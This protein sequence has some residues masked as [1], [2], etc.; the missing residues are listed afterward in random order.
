MRKNSLI[1]LITLKE[2]HFQR[3]KDDGL[4]W[5]EF[6]SDS[7]LGTIENRKILSRNQHKEI[8]H[9]FHF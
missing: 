3:R 6:F 4:N 5:D 8:L 9:K 2:G 7:I 1:V